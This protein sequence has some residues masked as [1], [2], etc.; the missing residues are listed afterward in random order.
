MTTDIDDFDV[1]AAREQLEQQNLRA[2]VR[3]DDAGLHKAVGA[4]FDAAEFTVIREKNFAA[5]IIP[6]ET[7]GY[8]YDDRGRRTLDPVHIRT[9]GQLDGQQTKQLHAA[10]A[11][12]IEH[13][14]IAA[15]DD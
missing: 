5:G 11:R 13:K 2:L 14:R 12:H 15:L 1:A 4:A 10:R 6:V 9:W 3:A 7:F 8:V